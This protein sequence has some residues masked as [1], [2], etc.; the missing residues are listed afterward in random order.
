MAGVVRCTQVVRQPPCRKPG[1]RWGRADHSPGQC[2]WRGWEAVLACCLHLTVEPE[3]AVSR[4]SSG[5]VYAAN[6]S[7]FTLSREAKRDQLSVPRPGDW[8]PAL[9]RPE[10]L[11][12]SLG[13]AALVPAAALRAGPEQTA[14]RGRPRL[15]GSVRA[16]ASFSPRLSDAVCTLGFHSS[17][18]G[19]KAWAFL[20]IR[21]QTN[22]QLH[23]G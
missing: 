11:S 15:D 21:D 12:C 23:P 19:C 9:H 22:K 14:G 7:K 6:S 20:E 1:S 10:G 13:P 8:G 3:S 16:A 17:P 4:Q 5:A 18:R 2:Q